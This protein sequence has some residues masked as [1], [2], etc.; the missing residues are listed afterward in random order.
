MHCSSATSQPRHWRR[1]SAAVMA[2]A[3]SLAFVPTAHALELETSEVELD[4]C[5]FTGAPH[6]RTF[7]NTSYGNVTIILQS[8]KHPHRGF[9]PRPIQVVAV[10]IPGLYVSPRPKTT[11]QPSAGFNTEDTPDV[12][13]GHVIAL[14]LGGPNDSRNIVPQWSRWQRHEEW[15]AMEQSLE[16]EAKRIADE[17]RHHGGPP[18][19]SVVMNVAIEYKEVT[20]NVTPTITTWAFPKTFYVTAYPAKIADPGRRDGDYILHNK[21]FEGEPP[22]H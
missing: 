19:R 1:L 4:E 14:S 7:N 9:G 2:G 10:I 3:M 5:W 18:T 20:G 22:H 15:R 12:D 17:S 11:P 21:K 6:H 13:N 16:K 8:L